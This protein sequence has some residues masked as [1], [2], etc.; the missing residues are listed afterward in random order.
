MK[1]PNWAEVVEQFGLT[2]PL[3]KN[4]KTSSEMLIEFNEAYAKFDKREPGITIEVE[5]DNF[6]SAVAIFSH[7]GVEEGHDIFIYSGTAK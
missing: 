7:A 3:S 1:I 5:K 4:Y 2:T 6:D